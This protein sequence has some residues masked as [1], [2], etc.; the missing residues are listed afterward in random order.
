MVE[1]AAHRADQAAQIDRVTKLAES[2]RTVLL[3]PTN[4]LMAQVIALLDTR[5]R[6]IDTTTCPT[7]YGK[8]LLPRGQHADGLQRHHT[9]DICPT[10]RRSKTLPIIDIT[11][12]LPLVENLTD[13]PTDNAIPFRLR[14]I[15]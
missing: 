13:T 5:V 10:C 3:T 14:S 2:A 4:E 12:L 6:V 9:G 15:S 1:W 7:C 11:G 8:G